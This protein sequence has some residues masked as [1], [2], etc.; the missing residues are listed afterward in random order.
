MADW[1]DAPTVLILGDSEEGLAMASE[2]AI[3]NGARI[4]GALPLDQG[5]ARLDSQIAVDLV[6]VDISGDLDPLLD[7]LLQRVEEGARARRFSS[8]VTVAQPAMVDLV[9]TCLTHESVQILI[10]RD[11]NELSRTTANELMRPALHLAEQEGAGEL[12]QR[13]PVLGSS[14]DML[15]DPF[16]GELPRWTLPERVAALVAE[17]LDAF[18]PELLRDII[19]AR[20]LRAQ[21]FGHGLFADPAWDILL[22]LFAARME[23]RSVA[24]SSLCIAAA[25]PATTALRWIRQLTDQALLRRVADPQDGRRVFIELTDSAVATMSAYFAAL[26]RPSRQV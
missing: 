23:G 17:N 26:A 12:G 10:G 4:V 25:V 5:V 9:L 6:L 11:R 18:D 13:K 1:D 20:R 7:P 21:F 16:E 19:R 2:A 14:A 24:V 3:A 15:G 22:D 8:I